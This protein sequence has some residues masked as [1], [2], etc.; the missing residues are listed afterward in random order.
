MNFTKF[1]KRA[2]QLMRQLGNTSETGT[3]QTREGNAFATRLIK[4]PSIGRT[5]PDVRKEK[6]SHLKFF[7][8]NE[9]ANLAPSIPLS[10]HELTQPISETN[11]TII[12]V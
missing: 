3:E 2:F 12:L 1:S 6:K 11:V 4:F 5:E 7:R 8:T 9:K 10:I